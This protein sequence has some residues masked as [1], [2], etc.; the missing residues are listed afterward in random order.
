MFLKKQPSSHYCDLQLLEIKFWINFY[1]F[2]LMDLIFFRID[3]NKSYSAQILRE[4]NVTLMAVGVGRG[5]NED[6]L[7]NVNIFLSHFHFM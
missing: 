3:F 5:F 7:R 6:F 2:L 1:N 4:Q